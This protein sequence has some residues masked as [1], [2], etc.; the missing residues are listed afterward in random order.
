MDVP[1]IGTG[2]SGADPTRTART[3]PP[4]G[5]LQASAKQADI[6]LRAD[7][8]TSLLPDLSEAEFAALLRIFEGLDRVPDTARVEQL[9]TAARSAAAQGNAGDAVAHLSQLA[10][11]DPSRVEALP[12]H[13]DLRPI[14]AEAARLVSDL[15]SR[16]KLDAESSLAEASK[17][18]EGREAGK[19]LLT[20]AGRLY[21]AGGYVNWLRSSALSQF[22]LEQTRWA[23]AP[24]PVASSAPKLR[25]TWRASSV[26][27][28]LLRGLRAGISRGRASTGRLWRRAPLLV[29][30]LGWLAVGIVFGV[31]AALWREATA[32]AASSRGIA[33]GFDVW[34]L[35]FLVL[36]LYGFYRRVRNVRF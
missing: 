8:F 12:D 19:A 6:E 29:L 14:R 32:A 27:P 24:I 13:P 22:I 4:P 1:G 10:V 16:A 21:E 30:L 25:A 11:L 23:P 3:L 31:T 5:G 33:A 26:D 15:V 18:M 2:L 36:V 7:A 9:F 35:G 34:G 28:A 20:S 17:S